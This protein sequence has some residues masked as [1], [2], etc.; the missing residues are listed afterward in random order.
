MSPYTSEGEEVQCLPELGS[1]RILSL[2]LSLNHIII[3]KNKLY[4]LS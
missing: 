4:D 2:F 3:F 1:L